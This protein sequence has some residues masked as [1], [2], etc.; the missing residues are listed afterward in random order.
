MKPCPRCR[1]G[2]GRYGRWREAG[3]LQDWGELFCPLCAYRERLP[4]ERPTLG[5][6]ARLRIGRHAYL[7]GDQLPLFLEG[8]SARAYWS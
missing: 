2:E 3:L 1:F 8:A 7:P 4:P 6:V 5:Q